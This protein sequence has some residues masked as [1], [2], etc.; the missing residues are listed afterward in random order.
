[1]TLAGFILSSAELLTG[2]CPV[3]AGTDAGRLRLEA[4]DCVNGMPVL[5]L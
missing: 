4:L 1:M 3:S 5:I 2:I